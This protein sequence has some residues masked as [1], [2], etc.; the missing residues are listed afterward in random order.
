MGDLK[1]ADAFIGLGNAALIND[2]DTS[3]GVRS[4]SSI[5]NADVASGKCIYIV[6]DAAPHTDI[7]QMC[8]DI[9]YNYD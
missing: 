2:F 1:W 7:T 6:F 4:D 8:V 9:T 5:T 3:S